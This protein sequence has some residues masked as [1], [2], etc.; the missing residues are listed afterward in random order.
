MEEYTVPERK[1]IL[2]NSL[3]NMTHLPIFRS[4]QLSVIRIFGFKPQH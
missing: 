4:D 1:N 2:K 3:E